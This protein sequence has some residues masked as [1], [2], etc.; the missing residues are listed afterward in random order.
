MIDTENVDNVWRLMNAK[1]VLVKR[2]FLCFLLVSVMLCVSK[3]AGG[4][5]RDAA[6][7]YI[8]K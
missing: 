4:Y 3:T 5:Y 8:G 7:Q 2:G 6:F 1:E